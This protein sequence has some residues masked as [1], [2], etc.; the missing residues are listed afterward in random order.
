MNKRGLGFLLLMVCSLMAAPS[1]ATW[2]S[3]QQE[4][5]GTRISVSLWSDKQGQ[6]EAA[7]AAVMQEMQRIDKTYSP[8]IEQSELARLNRLAAAAPQ[9]I[10]P[11]MQQLLSAAKQISVLSQGAFD[12]TFASVGHLYHYRKGQQ[13]TQQ[14]RQQRQ[15]AIDYRLLLMENNTLYFKH[16]DIRIDLGGIAKGYGVD[17][18]IAILRQHG[19]EHASV[20]AGGDSRLLG[21]RRGRPWIVGIKNPRQQEAIALRLPLDNAAVSTSGDYERF[22]IDRQSGE[23]VH[24][25]LNPGSG[26]PAQGVTSVTV[27][28]DTGLRTDPLST[29]VFVLGVDRGLSLLNRL[30]DVEGV[31]IDSQGKVHYSQGLL[32]PS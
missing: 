32:P 2:F 8:Y 6:A 4:L 27:I 26:R 20:S 31:I 21:D 5:M 16:P 12:I 25:I 23:R 3:E 29:T 11:E 9:P 13:P 30:P 28:G 19:I 17:R 7:I 15:P 1:G 18:A 22:F 24:H 10:S 14:Q